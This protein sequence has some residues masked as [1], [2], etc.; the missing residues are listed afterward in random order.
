MAI[1]PD[2]ISN[3]WFYSEK[4]TR[5]FHYTRFRTCFKL[6]DHPLRLL[7]TVGLRRSE[8][9]QFVIVSS[10]LSISSSTQFLSHPKHSTYPPIHFTPPSSLHRSDQ[11]AIPCSPARQHPITNFPHQDPTHSI[12]TYVKFIQQLVCTEHAIKEMR[13]SP[14]RSRCRGATEISPIC[15]SPRKSAPDNLYQ[16]SNYAC[17]FHCLNRKCVFNQAVFVHLLL[18]T[19]LQA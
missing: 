8:C 18:R 17:V 6:Y 9:N 14:S 2:S 19:D 16:P 12:P 13:P 3:V 11:I 4:E 10:S 1:R 5:Y 15:S 7:F